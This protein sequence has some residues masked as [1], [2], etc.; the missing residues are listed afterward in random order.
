MKTII[1]IF[2]LLV[3]FSCVYYPQTTKVLTLQYKT[4][5]L[6]FNLFEKVS[7]DRPTI[8]L[9]LSGGGARG[10]AQIGVLKAFEEYGI[11][12]DIIVGTSIGSV[13]GGLYASGYSAY[14]L[15]SI[16]KNTDWDNLLSLDRETNRRE[17]F[18]QV[19]KQ[20]IR[21]HIALL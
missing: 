3:L 7:Y 16:I 8:S 6:P 20:N 13:I 12:F 19:H 10:F 11:P 21:M 9:A 18:N 2:F 17:L 1:K 15:D 5:K 14:E 4:H